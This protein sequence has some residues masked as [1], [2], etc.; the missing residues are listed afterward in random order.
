M[1]WHQNEVIISGEGSVLISRSRG[2]REETPAEQGTPPA[3]CSPHNNSFQLLKPKVSFILPFLL[4]SINKFS[5]LYLSKMSRILC[6]SP[7][8]TIYLSGPRPPSSLPWV[9]RTT[10]HLVL[11]L[12]LLPLTIHHIPTASMI[13]FKYTSDLPTPL[14]ETLQ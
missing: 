5:Q 6:F 2:R 1:R 13:L 12:L 7:T 10:S 14:T 11:R 8:L 3:R 9:T 4:I